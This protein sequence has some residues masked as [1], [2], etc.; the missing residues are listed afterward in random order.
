[1]IPREATSRPAIVSIEFSN[2][3]CA[4]LLRL[5]NRSTAAFPDMPARTINVIVEA[6]PMAIQEPKKT[7]KPVKFNEMANINPA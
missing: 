4:F 2:I 3:L 6:I 5:D 7:P 1:M